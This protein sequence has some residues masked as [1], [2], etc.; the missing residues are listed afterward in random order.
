M[1]CVPPPCGLTLDGG[2]SGS[3]ISHSPSGT[4]QLHVPRPIPSPTSQAHIGHGLSLFTAAGQLITSGRQRIL[5]LARHW[6]F[7]GHITAAL[8]RLALLPNPG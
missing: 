6:P 1:S 4:I 2:I 8:E 5:R 7:T 3:A